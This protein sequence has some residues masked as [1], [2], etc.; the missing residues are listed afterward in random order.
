MDKGQ[1]FGFLSAQD[2]S[3]L[4]DLLSEAYDEMTIDQRRAVF[5][6]LVRE[7]PP[8]P[9]D[10]ETVLN[11]VEKFH[12]QSLDGYYYEPF[13]INSKNWMHVPEGTEEWFEEMGDLLKASCQLTAQEDHRHAVACFRILYELIDKLREG[14]EIVFGDEIGSWMIPGNEKE[15][16]A[17]YM[18]SLAAVASPEEF[19]AVA[20][21]ILRRDSYQSFWTQ[22]YA[23]AIRAADEAQ[24]VY[25]EAEIQRQNIRTKPKSQARG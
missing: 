10:G 3:T 1:L 18:T 8:A 5:G 24:R 12:R 22:A 7:L 20:I 9:V 14:E 19:A 16:V 13:D 21:P 4:L 25:L 6:G 23:S 17:A 15:H 2:P 11:R